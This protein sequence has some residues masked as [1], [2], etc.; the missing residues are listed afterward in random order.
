MARAR[1]QSQGKVIKHDRWT[2]KN[3][4][5]GNN[6]VV[7]RYD[8]QIPNRLVVFDSG[9]YVPCLGKRSQDFGS[10]SFIGGLK[11]STNGI[12]V[13]TTTAAV[14]VGVIALAVSGIAIKGVKSQHASSVPQSC[15]STATEICTLA[16]PPAT[17]GMPNPAARC[18]CTPR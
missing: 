12:T 5:Q 8:V 10:N 3:P 15:T 7:P 6:R 9:R 17:P 11:L 2:H 18:N 4:S 16:T 1:S 13:S 14:F